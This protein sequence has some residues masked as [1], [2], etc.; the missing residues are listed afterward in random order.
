MTVQSR[1]G[2]ARS[3]WEFLVDRR[4]RAVANAVEE[5]K[6]IAPTPRRV[7]CPSIEFLK[8]DRPR[9]FW[10]SCQQPRSHHAAKQGDS[11]MPENWRRSGPPR[12]AA[13]D[14]AQRRAVPRPTISRH[15]I[16]Q[17]RRVRAAGASSFRPSRCGYGEGRSTRPAG[18]RT[19]SPLPPVYDRSNCAFR[20]SGSFT[21]LD[22]PR[23][24][25]HLS[26][27]RSLQIGCGQR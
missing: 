2:R 26:H 1:K 20:Q 7:G 5:S 12:R 9:E 16:G 19:S 24:N 18:I 8:Q 21:T 27:H 11:T 13:S 23:P 6:A 10:R 25:R 15:R 3:A 14:F 17:T 22:R 4:Q